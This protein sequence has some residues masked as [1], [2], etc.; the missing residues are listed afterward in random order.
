MRLAIGANKYVNNPL[1]AAH[2]VVTREWKE[3]VSPDL[4]NEFKV[5]FVVWINGRFLAPT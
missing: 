3:P 1:K 5:A 4:I 2:S